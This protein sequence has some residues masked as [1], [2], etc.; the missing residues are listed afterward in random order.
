[1]IRLPLFYRVFAA[2]PFIT[3]KNSLAIV[4][5]NPSNNFSPIFDMGKTLTFSL[6]CSMA[7]KKED[8]DVKKKK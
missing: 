7:K 2:R 4:A 3:N 8:K 5:L 6:K 1:M